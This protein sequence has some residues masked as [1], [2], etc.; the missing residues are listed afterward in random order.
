[1]KKISILMVAFVAACMS[2]FAD[3]VVSVNPNPLQ[4]SPGDVVKLEIVFENS[5]G[6]YTAFDLDISMPEGISAELDEGEIV[7]DKGD[8]YGKKDD[9]TIQAKSLDSGADN[10]MC[11]STSSKTISSGKGVVLVVSYKVPESIATGEYTGKLSHITFATV[12]EKEV[13]FDDVE[14][15]VLVVPT[16]IN[17]VPVSKQTKGIYN[18]SGQQVEM[19]KGINIVDGK[20][21]MVK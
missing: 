1:M 16:K 2:A 12:D 4:V 5:G 8:L 9:H 11:F 7:C 18:V 3:D 17:E 6:N 20:K 15:K 13:E 21:V 19:Q 14:F 10:F